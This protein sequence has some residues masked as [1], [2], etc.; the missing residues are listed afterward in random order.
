VIESK[1]ISKV[2]ARALH[3][4]E[5]RDDSEYEPGLG[6]HSHLSTEEYLDG[7][8][9]FE[10]VERSSQGSLADTSP[11]SS[12]S[13]TDQISTLR[14]RGSHEQNIAFLSDSGSDSESASNS[15]KCGTLKKFN[16]HMNL[17]KMTVG[18]DRY[19]RTSDR[20][21]NKM[22]DL[23][24]RFE[25][26]N[27]EYIRYIT[28]DPSPELVAQSSTDRGNRSHSNIPTELEFNLYSSEEF[29][30]MF[31]PLL[32]LDCDYSEMELLFE[33][34]NSEDTLEIASVDNLTVN[35]F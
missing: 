32:A 28:P 27:I 23:E 35:S 7:D 30:P 16:T 26:E 33:S 6:R 13:I 5:N 9:T 3:A 2:F 20:W 22:G 21:R 14:A 34:A 31:F 11:L 17:E 29:S 8:E 15:I 12:C 1:E 19:S 10:I 24:Q 25:G 18:S 4:E